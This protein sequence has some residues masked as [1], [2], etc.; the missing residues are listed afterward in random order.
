MK[1]RFPAAA[2]YIFTA[3]GLISIAALFTVVLGGLV[4]S[5]SEI[6]FDAALSAFTIE[7]SPPDGKYGIL[8]MIAGT[9]VTAVIATL[10][11]IPLSFGIISFIWIYDNVL[12][13]FMRGLLRF[14]SGIP[15]VVYAFCG[16]FILIPFARDM[17]GGSGY[18]ILTVSAVL[19][20]LILPTMTLVA[21]SALSSFIKSPENPM[22]AAAS[23]GMKREKSFLY[24]AVYAQRKWL[25]TGVL[26][27]FS[28][29]LGDTMVALMLSGNTP[30]MPGG[31]LSSVRTLSGHINLLTA[32][33]ISPQV[34]FTLF[35]SGFLLF[36]A[37]LSVSFVT[38]SL[39]GK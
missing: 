34:E 10:G 28:R 36:A 20:L 35:L 27:A 5:A 26:L 7:W 4:Y 3:A 8:P 25:L 21:D 22:L 16:V 9:A 19:C 15:T 2:V 1:R 33:E 18:N 23:L 29:A 39:R 38:R 12:S 14:M 31:M 37:A 30:V 17:W 32:T 11:A 24:V 6:G 13:R